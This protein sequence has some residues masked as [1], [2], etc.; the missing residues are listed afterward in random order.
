MCPQNNI[1]EGHFQN[2]SD[3]AT[4]LENSIYDD[5]RASR[6]IINVILFIYCMNTFIKVVKKHKEHLD[7][8]HILTLNAFVDFTL[9]AL[10]LIILDVITLLFPVTYH[11]LIVLQKICDR[12]IWF[13]FIM[14]LTIQG[15][16][17]INY[18]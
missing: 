16:H 13:W 18:H 4:L 11:Y 1:I 17:H 9:S 15:C 14:D 6:L 7:P 8:V 10:N 5:D 2:V 3:N 12:I